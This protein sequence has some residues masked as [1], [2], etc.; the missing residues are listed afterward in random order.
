MYGM[1]IEEMML[2][3]KIFA[4]AMGDRNVS[5]TQLDKDAAY[6]MLKRMADQRLDWTEAQKEQFKA[7]VDGCK[8]ARE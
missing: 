7:L 4:F 1:T 3:A 2:C 8:Q 5:M 6:A